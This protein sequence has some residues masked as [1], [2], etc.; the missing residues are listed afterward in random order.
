METIT[1]R[2]QLF[3]ILA[4]PITHVKTPERI[5]P[6]LAARPDVGIMAPMHVPEG[7]LEQVVR[8]LKAIPNLQGFVVTVPHK[9]AMLPLCDEVTEQAR[10]AGAVNVVRRLSDG[11]LRG[12]LLDGD[13]FVQGLRSAG[14]EPAGRSV[15]LAGAGGAAS[16]IAMA[17]AKAGIR[18]LTISNR[19][20]ERVGKLIESLCRSFPRL[21]PVRG[22]NDPS[23]HDI[24]VNA[25]SLG[26]RVDDALPFD[27]FRLEAGQVVAEII[28][29]PAETPI[30]KIA[31]ERGCRVHGG[32]PMLDAQVELMAK[33]MGED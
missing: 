19:N 13:G 7:A 21:A 2:T 33:F 30:L 11:R 22:S 5:N 28:M 17:L 4:D 10:Q 12:G 8:G 3:L 15:Y 20:T 14:V 1:G 25:T 26:L 31:R 6:L 23:G 29:D 9:A 32:M 18:H 16:A 24:V 27:A